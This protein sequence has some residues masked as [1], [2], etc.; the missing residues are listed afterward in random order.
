MHAVIYERNEVENGTLLLKVF[1]QFGKIKKLKIPGILK[2][3]TRNAYFLAPATL[4]EFTISGNEREVVTPKEYTLIHSP[5][6]FESSYKELASIGE[7]LKPMNYLKPD[8]EII[9]LFN[10]L[11][12]ILYNWK[13]GDKLKEITLS[14]QFYL[15]FLF[16]M[17][18]LNFSLQCVHCGKILS[19][20]AR[21]HLFSGSICNDCIKEQIY[22]EN[23][24]IPNLWINNGINE[25]SNNGIFTEENEM[26]YRKRIIHYLKSSI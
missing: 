25:I 17:G 14:N 16:R 1:T 10:D 15:K 12:K 9:P 13:C 21:Y 24:F 22:R 2:S 11:S 3:K 8:L 19:D 20:Q 18:L 5:Y 7:V 4:W 23:E 6:S 26:D